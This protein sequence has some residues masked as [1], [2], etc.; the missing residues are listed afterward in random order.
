LESLRHVEKLIASRVYRDRFVA[1]CI[2][3]DHAD[4]CMFAGWSLRLK[5]LRWQAVAEFTAEVFVL[6]AGWH[7]EMT[8]ILN[9]RLFIVNLYPAGR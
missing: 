8:S 9:N 7:F 1:H 5:S 3:I 4:A 6:I 2:P